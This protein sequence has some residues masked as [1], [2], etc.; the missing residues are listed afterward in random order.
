MVD[1]TPSKIYCKTTRTCIPLPQPHDG[2]GIHWPF[3]AIVPQCSGCC[4][5]MSNLLTCKPVRQS[6]H[7]VEVM[8]IPYA[9]SKYIK[10]LISVFETSDAQRM[11]ILDFSKSTNFSM[12]AHTV[13]TVDNF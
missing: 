11:Y 5:L 6:T 8:Y 12:L 9:Q 2:S 1:T 3:C 10:Y 13:A 4:D 7:T